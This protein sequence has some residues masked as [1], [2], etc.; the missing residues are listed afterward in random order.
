MFLRLR[1]TPFLCICSLVLA[2]QATDHHSQTIQL[3]V[4][5]GTP[6]RAY[7]TKRMPKRLGAPVEATT[8]S[9]IFTFDRETIPSGSRLMGHVSRIEP[10]S[11][12]ARTRAILGGDFTP[13]HVA[14][15]QFTSVRIH[16]GRVMP[17]K[18]LETGG[19]NT[20]YP[21]RPPKPI[22]QSVAQ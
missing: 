7:L 4:T 18:T 8:I 19:L 20:L 9:P 11:K 13:L 3:T 21:I 10:V 2:Y 6:L 15:V 22:T 14:Q 16:D 5:R 17:I 12:S 1:H